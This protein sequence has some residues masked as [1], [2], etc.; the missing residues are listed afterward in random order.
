MAIWN[1]VGRAT[2]KPGIGRMRVGLQL[3][4]RLKLGS[5]ENAWI[6]KS[7]RLARIIGKQSKKSIRVLG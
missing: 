4:R 5:E 6:V 7:S 2:L 3:G 1:D